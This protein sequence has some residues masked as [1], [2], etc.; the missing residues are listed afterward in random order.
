MPVFALL[1][2]LGGLLLAT[3]LGWSP[4]LGGLVGLLAPTVLLCIL[5]LAAG[6]FFPDVPPCRCGRSSSLDSSSPAGYEFLR[7]EQA[8]S[9]SAFFYHCRHCGRCY[10]HRGDDFFLVDEDGAEQPHSR[11]V[12]GRWQ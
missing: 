2:G 7:V 10:A 6:V 9:E 12:R 11:R 3:L 1:C 8:G 5:Y 4:A